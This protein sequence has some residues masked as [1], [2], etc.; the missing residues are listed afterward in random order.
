VD[1]HVPDQWQRR[2]GIAHVRD[3]VEDARAAEIRAR[4]VVARLLIWAG[5][6]TTIGT[7]LMRPATH[8]SRHIAALA[9]VGMCAAAVIV[10]VRWGAPGLLRGM[11]G[12][13]RPALRH[14]WRIRR[15]LSTLVVVNARRHRRG[16][17]EEV[18]GRRIVVGV[19]GSD[20]SKRALHWAIEQAALTG[21]T[22]EAVGV[23]EHLSSYA[24]G[25]V[26]DVDAAELA[27][28]CEQ[29]VIDTVTEV[30]GDAPPV[31]IDSYIIRGHPANELVRQAKGADLLVVGSRGHS[32]LVGALL[33]SVSNYCVHHA[34]CPVVVIRDGHA[35][36]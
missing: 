13:W 5:A 33:G 36:G 16:M 9:F 4:A 18:N 28:A 32:G 35:E 21:V 11:T 25:A 14:I 24:W 3:D 2:Y 19:D 22:V 27:D 7:G 31:H 10:F 20:P 17:S 26:A 30:G 12:P 6:V 29:I 34:D 1:D 23:W 8:L 15:G